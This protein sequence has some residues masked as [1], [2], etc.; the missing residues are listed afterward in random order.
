MPVLSK[1]TVK[2]PDGV[3]PC[4]L[5]EDNTMSWLYLE[6]KRCRMVKKARNI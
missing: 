2:I 4:R 3:I 5:H 1:K 6:A